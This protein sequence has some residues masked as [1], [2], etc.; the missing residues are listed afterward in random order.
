MPTYEYHCP[1]CEHDFALKATV[2]EYEDGLDDACP[3]CDSLNTARRLGSVLISVGSSDADT[4][5]RGRS[6]PQG[7][8]CT[9]DGGCC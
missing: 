5:P 4:V 1:D 2:T 6:S 9:P 8:C 7:G 3:K